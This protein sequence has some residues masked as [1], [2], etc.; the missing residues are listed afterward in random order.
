MTAPAHAVIDLDAVRHNVGLLTDRAGNAEVM[1]VVKADAYG[2]GLLPVARAALAGG[3]GWLGVAR[4]EEAILLRAGLDPSGARPRI[5]TWLYVPGAPLAEALEADLDVSVG[6]PWALTEVAAAARR[7]GRTARVHLKVDTGMSRVGVRPEDWAALVDQAMAEQAQGT[8][9]VVGVWSH[10]TSADDPDDP[11][12][13]A[14]LESFTAAVRTAETAGVRPQVRHLAASSGTLFH[15]RTHL[16]L[17]RPGIAVYG[18]SPAPRVADAARLGLRAAMRVETT[19]AAV[20]TVPAGT[21]VSYNHTEVT[22]TA[23]RLGVLPVGYANGI[24][25]HASGTGPVQVA[26]RR[27]TVVGRVCM[28]QTVVDLGPE[29]DGTDAGGSAVIFGDGADGEPTAEDWARATG[30]IGYEIV[31]RMGSQV[32]RRYRGED[33]G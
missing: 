23:T 11:T 32:P 13:E 19:L 15:P 29:D 10:L 31:T 26:G 4:V 24:P 22:G 3:A 18:I 6:A 30:T 2:H 21:P 8:V 9:E 28:D 25:R 27:C 1:A 17:V 33:A 7:T 16:D 20:K 5:L 12:T 14:Q